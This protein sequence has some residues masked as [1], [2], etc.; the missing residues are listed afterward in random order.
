M[1][2][3]AQRAVGEVRPVAAP[4]PGAR[5]TRTR[6]R[7]LPLA[8]GALGL[9]AA[10]GACAPAGGGQ[11]GPAASRAPVTVE[12]WTFWNDERLAFVRP[13]LPK[14]EAQTGYVRATLTPDATLR[15]KLRTVLAAGT[16]PD[17]SIADVFSAALYFDNGSILDLKPALTRDRV[18]LR[19]DWVLKGGKNPDAAYELIKFMGMDEVQGALGRERPV[20][21]AKQ[22]VRH[23]KEGFLKSP[24]AHMP[25]FNDI[26]DNGYYRAPFIF[27][28]N[29]LETQR[30]IDELVVPA[31][32]DGAGSVRDACIEA[33]RQ[34]NQLVKYGERCFKPPWKPR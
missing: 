13:E 17:A 10:L 24:P 28:Y 15:D 21:P 27:Q 31:V 18:N 6:R 32:A 2:A 8:T 12:Y 11:T 14:L 1:R 7:L 4:A 23:D 34:A 29:D 3:R 16:P 25:V 19:R 20:Q 26:W 5:G 33:N 30:K 22:S 9:G